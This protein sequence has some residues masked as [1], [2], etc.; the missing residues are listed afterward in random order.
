MTLH[1]STKVKLK[2][3]LIC[4]CVI[5]GAPFVSVWV[6]KSLPAISA[7]AAKA[8]S[9]SAVLNFGEMYPPEEYFS[10]QIESSSQTEETEAFL[11][12]RIMLSEGM[13]Y[14]Y[15]AAENEDAL[16]PDETESTYKGPSPYP[17]SIETHSGTITAMAYLEQDGKQFFDLEKF[18][19][20]RNA[21]E[22]P[23]SKL[24]EESKKLPEFK[25]DISDEE[26]KTSEPQVLIM[27]THTTESFEP[28]A[29]DFYDAS[30]NSRTTDESKNVVSVGNA[31]EKELTSQGIGVIHDKTVHDYPSY[32]GSYDRSRAT[33]KA[34]LAQHPSIKVV[35]DIH[36]DAIEREGGERIAPT[37]TVDGKQAAQVMIISGCDN[38]TMNMPNYLKNFRLASLFQQQLEGD[39][40]GL[41]RP[42]LFT[43]KKYNQDLTTGSLLIEVG[44]HANSVEQAQYSGELV[45]KSLANALKGISS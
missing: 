19:Q 11:D 30:F 29:R 41:T 15:N 18:G 16:K 8:A 9:F 1:H 24:I 2:K 22:I 6:I 3:V 28:Y 20:V 33:V 34:I 25:I 40:P 5:A 31:I 39:Y 7:A 10:S 4:L 17:E 32:N 13:P 14:E 38:G 36:R 12:D 44:G 45:G 42:V 21:T 27:H 35:L 23:M 26:G 43:Y 37:V